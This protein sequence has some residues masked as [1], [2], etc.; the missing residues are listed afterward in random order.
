MAKKSNDNKKAL[1][2]ISMHK[3]GSGYKLNVDLAPIGAKLDLAQFKLD[4]KVWADVQKY[5]P[6]GMSGTGGLISMTN[7]LN[8]TVSG[9]VYMYPPDSKY[10]H[11]Q[12]MGEVYVDPVTHA[13]GFLTDD[14]WKSRKNVK[15]V[16][17]GRALKYSAP[18]ARAKWGEVAFKNHEAEWLK[19]VEAAIKG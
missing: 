11:Y 13:A 19:V 14:G 4:A 1:K 9:K 3:T 16:P 2:K 7:A 12:Y 17:S 10:G 8:N 6:K 5:M 18:N 15:K